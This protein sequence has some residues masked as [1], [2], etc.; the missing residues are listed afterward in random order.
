MVLSTIKRHI[1][2]TPVSRDVLLVLACIAAHALYLLVTYLRYGYFSFP[3]DDAWIYQ[4]YAR[5]LAASGQWAFVSGVPSTGSTSI[6][7]T[8]LIAP[9]YLL[10]IDPLWWTHLL[11]LLCL[12]A[13]SLGGARLFGEDA[14]GKSLAVGLA[15]AFEWHLVWAAASG[16]E[17]G[18]FSAML[19]WF[20]VWLRRRDPAH[21][22]H[23]LR[24]GLILGL[25][26]GG[27]MLAR[28]EGVL[29]F[30]I[31][32]LYGVICP[33]K[34]AAR[35]RWGLVAGAGFAVLLAPFLL[36]NYGIGGTLWPNTF[37]AKQT[38]YAS[39]WD[40]PYLTRFLEQV[41]VCLIG[42]QVLLVPALLAHLWRRFRNRPVE[43]VSL[44]PWAWALAHWALYTARLPVVY[45]HGRYAIP[46]I[47]ILVIYGIR[48]LLELV[49]PRARQV[50][51]RL[52]GLTWMLATGLLFPLFVSVSGA[53]A[54]ADDVAYIEVE[55]VATARWVAEHTSADDIVAAHD[56]GALG[57][58]APRRLVDLAGLVS[59]DVIPFMND[60]GRLANYIVESD[61]DYL[62]VF[63]GWSPA[64]A[65]L[66]SDPRLCR[67]WSASDAGEYI[68]YSP[69]LGPM[70][71]Y[72]VSSQENCS[73]TIP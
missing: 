65:R 28:P 56:I 11:G 9:A 50:S 61:S 39:L 49:R 13:M 46:V 60:A 48:G 17:T 32:W 5:N 51:I 7:W 8:W 59:P 57:Y 62:I 2:L 33:G 20:W 47:P 69:D 70:T 36:L 15:V 68:S 30:G 72:R 24:D 4:V 25:W 1:S 40:R 37:Y 31:A 21:V 23:N 53:P 6:L 64:Y 63:P 35:F 16:M 29:A 22:G 73:T 45:Q 38:E 27:L 10:R 14:P 66:V 18:L 58:F 55:M 19:I 44:L 41:G 26:G 71:V 52:A 54:Y 67:I 3:L 12:N 43:W 42:A 34:L